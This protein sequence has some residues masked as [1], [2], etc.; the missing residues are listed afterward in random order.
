MHL[1]EFVL[2]SERTRRIICN[3]NEP[4]TWSAARLVRLAGLVCRSCACLWEKDSGGKITGDS[5]TMSSVGFPS[6]TTNENHVNSRRRAE[7]K[8]KTRSSETE[9]RMRGGGGNC[10][11]KTNSAFVQQTRNS[12]PFVHFSTLRAQFLGNPGKNNKTEHAAP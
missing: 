9:Q 7:K 2:H 10:V 1:C 6:S 5:S 8:D 4:E 3:R 12:Q 11:L